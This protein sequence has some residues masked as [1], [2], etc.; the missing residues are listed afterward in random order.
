MDGNRD[1]GGNTVN[2]F[3]LTGVIKLRTNERDPNHIT[4]GQ[5]MGTFSLTGGISSIEELH[6]FK[7]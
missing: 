6:K 1:G 7:S 3:S 4:G 2:R 5:L